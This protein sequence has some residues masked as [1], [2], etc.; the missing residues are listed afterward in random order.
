MVLIYSTF[1]SSLPRN[2]RPPFFSDLASSTDHTSAVFVG[3][4]FLL[5][6]SE[7]DSNIEQ[8]WEILVRIN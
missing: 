7:K 6:S 1:K 5:L 2:I 4:E 8:S 3:P